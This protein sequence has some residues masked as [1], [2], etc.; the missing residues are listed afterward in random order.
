MN[1][2]HCRILSYDPESNFN[3]N[4]FFSWERKVYEALMLQVFNWLALLL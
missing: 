3:L 2:N 4:Q 1:K